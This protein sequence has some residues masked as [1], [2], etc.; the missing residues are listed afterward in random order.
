MAKG[1]SSFISKLSGSIDKQDASF[2]TRK[3]GLVIEKKPVPTQ[4]TSYKKY[5][6][7]TVYSR[8]C[9]AWHYLSNSQKE[10]FKETAKKHGITLFNA[11]LKTYLPRYIT[12]RLFK[13]SEIEVDTDLDMQGK[14]IKNILAGTENSDAINYAQLKA[15]TAL[16]EIYSYRRAARYHTMAFG[17]ATGTLAVGANTLRV[18][19]FLVAKTTR[20]D[21]IAIHV[22]TAASGTTVLLGMYDDENVY[23]KNLIASF[24]T[25]D[26]ASTGL[27]ELSINLTLEPGLYWLAL[28]SNGNPTLGGVAASACPAILGG[29]TPNETPANSY[30]ITQTTQTLPHPFP[31]GASVASIPYLI[32]IRVAP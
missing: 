5:I 19:P 4:T 29:T 3:S 20:F 1:K 7:K 21:R 24:G 8:L 14:K 13:L 28:I 10:E 27:R 11:F 23:P 12:M 22:T 15:Y 16:T 17:G 25:V 32:A 30:Y 9:N 31:N 18:L 26:S 6:V 2:Q